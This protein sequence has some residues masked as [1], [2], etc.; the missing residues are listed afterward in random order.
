[1][2]VI[3]SRYS[4]VSVKAALS[5]SLFSVYINDLVKEINNLT[6]GIYV[7]GSMLSLLLYAE[8]IALLAPGERCSQ[9]MLDY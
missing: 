6:C 2:T 3:H 9:R 7:E 4:R 1:M 5:P 8:E